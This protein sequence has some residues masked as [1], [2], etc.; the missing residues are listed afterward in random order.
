MFEH[1]LGVQLDLAIDD[2]LLTSFFA[3]VDTMVL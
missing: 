3:T 2:L 1:Q